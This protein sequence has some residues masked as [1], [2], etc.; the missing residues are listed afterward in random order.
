VPGGALQFREA[1]QADSERI[2][3]LL[4]GFPLDARMWAPQLEAPPQGWRVIAPDLPGFG[5][6]PAGPDDTLT[7][8]A[9]ADAVAAL[10]ADLGLRRVVVA[11][12]SMGGYVAFALQRRH[13]ALFRA[14]VLCDTRAGADSEE[15]RRGR[16][17]AAA[18]VVRDGTDE[19]IDGLVPKLFSP[20]TVA[21]RPQLV[22]AVR[23]M[24]AEATPSAVAAALLGMAARPDASGQLREVSVPA[25]VVVG[26]DDSI[27]PVTE[28]QLLARAIP[29]A[30]LEIIN[31]AGHLPN[32]ENPAAFNSS[33]ARFLSG[34][35]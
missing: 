1:G 17:Q 7:M 30:S 8:D 9:A 12:L 5:S 28:V 11:G 32:L 18:R 19:F 31:D 13:P 35:P 6:S 20:R 27:S 25:L 26:E 29:G 34:L 24:M 23:D 21:G 16:L 2:I 22:A 10:A 4:H 15:V 3:L 14:L 33:L